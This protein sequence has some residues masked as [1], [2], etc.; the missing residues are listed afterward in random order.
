MRKKAQ[1]AAAAQPALQSSTPVPWKAVN[2]MLG[3]GV[4]PPDIPQ[5][6]PWVGHEA[7]TEE[8]VD[9]VGSSDVEMV[10]EVVVVTLAVVEADVDSAVVEIILEVVEEADV[11]SS[12]DETA[13]E[14]VVEA[15]VSVV[16]EAIDSSL[17]ERMTVEKVPR[18]DVFVVNAED[19]ATDEPGLQTSA[20]A[21]AAA[22]T[23]NP[24]ETVS[25]SKSRKE[26]TGLSPIPPIFYF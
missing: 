6:R 26:T 13:I 18:I 15:V 1:S 23:D 2:L 22:K 14:V 7:V 11:D 17:V 25:T 4:E 19:K 8:V 20:S 12:V 5:T 21:A 3:L 16:V 10:M 9:D 24:L